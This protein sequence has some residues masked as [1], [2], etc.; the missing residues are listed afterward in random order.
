MTVTLNLDVQ[1]SHKY[2]STLC[3]NQAWEF[4]DR[5]GERSTEDNL[6]MLHAAIASLWHWS[7]RADV[8]ARELAVGHWQVSRVYCLLR[9]PHNA[10]TYGLQSLKYARGL[11]PFYKGYAYETL[12]RAEMIV[13]NRVIMHTHLE[14]AYE[15]LARIEDDEERELLAK[16]LASI[17]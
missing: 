5:A 17:R 7:Q 2:F 9:Q 8:S 16:D 3:F 12:A 10:R 6:A 1:E 13:N 4:I 15:M 11:T 14:Q